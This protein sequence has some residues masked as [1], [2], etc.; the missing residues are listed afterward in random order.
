M[1]TN[2]IFMTILI[3]F[4]SLL[5]DL[6]SLIEKHFFVSTSFGNWFVIRIIVP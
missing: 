4:L 2:F 5:Y 6:D 1:N 3:L